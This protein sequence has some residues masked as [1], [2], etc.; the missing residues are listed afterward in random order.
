MPVALVI[1]G[2]AYSQGMKKFALVVLQAYLAIGLAASFSLTAS[3][4][5][6]ERLKPN[7]VTFFDVSELPE[8]SDGF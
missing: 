4:S 7:A 2:I 1:P 6:I 3:A 8:E 5:T